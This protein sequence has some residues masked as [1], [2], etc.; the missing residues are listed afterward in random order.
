ML[1]EKHSFERRHVLY[2]DILGFS[3]YVKGEFFE[4]SRCFRMFHRLDELV[5]ECVKEI[6]PSSPEPVT[7]LVPHYIVNPEAIYFSDS[8]VISTAPTNVD[9]MWLCEAAGRI[10]NSLCH[11][12]F[13]VRGAITTGDIY[14]SGN[15][16]FGPAIVRAVEMEKAVNL[17][18]IE[19]SD[20]THQ[21]FH[22]AHTPEDKEIVAARSRQLISGANSDVPF[23]DPFWLLKC[24]SS[25]STL[26]PHTKSQIE[27]WRALI[28]H[29]L[30]SKSSEVRAKY[31]WGA[32]H[33]N[34]SL[35][36]GP[37]IIKPIRFD[38]SKCEGAKGA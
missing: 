12:G 30:L 37:S 24:H 36:N 3:P 2:C 10:Q 4:P 14:H 9:A 19:I 34:Y 21:I 11:F 5:R 32:Q 20:E 26:H 33:F 15:T 25:Q 17:P 35:C 27:S 22:A 7:G 16:I 28:E 38:S 23:V 13:L 31:R 6:D 8:I 1:S 18:I 29:G